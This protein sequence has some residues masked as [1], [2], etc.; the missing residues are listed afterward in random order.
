MSTHPTALDRDT[1]RLAMLC[2]ALAVLTILGWTLYLTAP[3]SHTT[4]HTQTV[5]P[6]PAVCRQAARTW[7]TLA[8]RESHIA[9]LAMRGHRKPAGLAAHRTARYARNKAAAGAIHTHDCP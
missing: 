7:Q 1:S 3:T 4:V 8:L 9:T 2:V 5:T 6:P